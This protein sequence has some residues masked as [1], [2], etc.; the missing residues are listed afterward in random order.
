MY[1]MA[2]YP[3]LLRFPLLAESGEVSHHS[4]LNFGTF[5]QEKVREELKDFGLREEVAYFEI[6]GLSAQKQFQF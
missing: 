4:T 6:K 5:F 3:T 1:G 2:F